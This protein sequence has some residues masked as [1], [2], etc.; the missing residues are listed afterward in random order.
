MGL[1]APHPAKGVALGAR[2]TTLLGF[3]KSTDFCVIRE[4]T[5]W[6]EE[7]PKTLLPPFSCLGDE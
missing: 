1:C 2:Y 4:K 7:P 6:G 3:R 5:M